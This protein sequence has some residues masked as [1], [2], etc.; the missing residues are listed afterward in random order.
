MHSKQRYFGV[1]VA[2]REGFEPSEPVRAHTLSRRTT[3]HLRTPKITAIC[4]T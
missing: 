3:D 1:K 4:L 2:E